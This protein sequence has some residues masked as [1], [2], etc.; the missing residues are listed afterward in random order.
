MARRVIEF[1]KPP[2]PSAPETMIK[3]DDVVQHVLETGDY[4]FGVLSSKR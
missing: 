4:Y 1:D 3:G 2:M